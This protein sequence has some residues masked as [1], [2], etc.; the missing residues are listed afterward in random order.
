MLGITMI[1]KHFTLDKDLPGPDHKASAT[2]AELSELVNTVRR[3][4]KM[5]GE[6]EKRVTDSER[7]NIIVARKSIVAAGDIRKGEVFTADNIT[8]KRPGNGI[9][10]MYWKEV[11]GRIAETDFAVDELIHVSGIPEQ[12][13]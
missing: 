9:S 11:L 7:G 6:K 2:P 12:K 1:E 5:R 10:P 13:V 4:E 3:I 8:C